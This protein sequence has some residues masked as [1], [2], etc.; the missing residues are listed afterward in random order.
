MKD[1]RFFH[2]LSNGDIQEFNGELLDSLEAK[3]ECAMR[4]SF[5][6]KG[7][8]NPNAVDKV[9]LSKSAACTET[10]EDRPGWGVP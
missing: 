4:N 1:V 10:P 2:L 9:E 8:Y 6:G 5:V 3:A 7:V